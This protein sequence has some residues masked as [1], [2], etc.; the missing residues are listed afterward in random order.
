M[1]LSQVKKT[2]RK[3]KNLQLEYNEFNQFKWKTQ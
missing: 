2:T 1:K 3:T